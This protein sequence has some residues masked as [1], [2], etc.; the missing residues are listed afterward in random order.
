MLVSPLVRFMLVT[1]S[2]YA[3]NSR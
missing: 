3:P 2:V 1:P